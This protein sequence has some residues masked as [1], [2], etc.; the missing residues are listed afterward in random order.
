M[1]AAASLDGAAGPSPAQCGTG[2]PPAVL[3]RPS[4]TGAPALGLTPIPSAGL[5]L[6]KPSGKRDGKNHAASSGMALPWRRGRGEGE[7]EEWQLRAEKTP[8]L[9]LPHP[10]PTLQL[11][12]TC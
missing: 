1:P 2:H 10:N 11:M 6:W 3:F 8:C 5:L 9:A 12:E 7:G 4:V